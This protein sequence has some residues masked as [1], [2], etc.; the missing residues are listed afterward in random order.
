MTKLRV[1]LVDDHAVVREGLKALI[2]AQPELE[3]V[4]EA[5]DGPAGVHLAESVQPDVV[6]MDFTMPGMSGAE[7]TARLKAACPNVKILALTVHEDQGY[8]RRFFEAGATGYILKQAPA[9]EVFKAIQV[10][11]GGGVYLDPAVAGKAV[12]KLFRN[13]SVKTSLQ[14]DTLSERE[15]EVARLIARGLS[16]KEIAARLSINAKT[17]ET[18]KARSLTKLGLRSR[19][20]LVRYALQRGWLE[21]L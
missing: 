5:A 11:A 21:D 19:A 8:F 3:V 4:G 7:A 9:A 10:V 17:V 6:V 20:D 2:N 1:L 18:Y 14:G 13:D 12:G 16:N 15:S